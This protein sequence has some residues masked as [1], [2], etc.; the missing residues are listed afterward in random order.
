MSNVYRAFI[1]KTIEL[2]TIR[3]KSDEP[4]VSS[5]DQFQFTGAVGRYDVI[6]KNEATNNIE[7]FSNLQGV[8]TI[9]FSEGVGTYELKIRPKGT[10]NSTRFRRL[11]FNAGGDKDKL[12]EIKKWGNVKWDSMTFAFRQCSN[13]DLT[14]DDTPDL[15]ECQS[16]SGMFSQM[17]L[18]GSTAN[19]NWDVST[20]TDMSRAFGTNATF[21]QDI[22]GWDTSNVVNMSSMFSIA[23]IFNQDI[24]GWDTSNVVDMGGMFNAATAFNQDIGG[25]DVSS[26]IKMDEMFRGA[27]MFN[28]DIGG[29]I[30]SN[31]TTMN[32]MFRGA[33]AFNQDIGGWDVSDVTNMGFMFNLAAAFNQDIGGW[34]V[35]NVEDMGTM[36]AQA[37]AFNQDI[38]GWDT[39]NVKNM[40]NMFQIA[41]A[42][43]QD[44][45]G[46]DVSSVTNIS[47]MFNGATAF[48]QD[49]GGWDVSSVTNFANFM[50]G[51]NDSNYSAA[52]LDSIY[53]GWSLL[54]LQPNI[55]ISFGTI[56]YTASGQAGKDILE[57]APNNWLITDGG[58]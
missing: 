10:S 50:L 7:T 49:I 12:I 20:I 46:W 35:S 22:G 31:V 27:T 6:A 11:I 26:V 53:N 55:T 3:V 41:T 25:W 18:D 58:I 28:Q 2:F 1:K 47:A 5:N 17:N 36:F 56:K 51:K 54:A 32:S 43:N 42:F 48:N 33:A 57:G 52:N 44:I 24:G 21:N 23:T 39:S 38:G 4:G 34:D 9:T 37:T 45:G 29:W 16:I 14:A 15:S 19:W 13:L 30:T 40:G 8:Q